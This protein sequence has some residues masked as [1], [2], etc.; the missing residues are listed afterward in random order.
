MTAS[1]TLVSGI[2][3]AGVL[4]L[5]NYRGIRELVEGAI[6]ERIVGGEYLPGTPLLQ[7]ELAD[8]FGVSR[9]PIRQALLTL[10][11]EGL[12]VSRPRRPSVVAP[13]TLKLV[14]DVYEIRAVLD[15]LAAMRAAT[16]H[17]VV[18]PELAMRLGEIVEVARE[19]TVP[20]QLLELDHQFHREIYV[21]S[22]N[23]VGLDFFDSRWVVIGRVM[24]V[25]AASAYLTTAW[26]E[27]REMVTLIEHGDGLAVRELAT[28][29][30]VRARQ[31]VVEHAH[32]L[33]SHLGDQ[34]FTSQGGDEAEEVPRNR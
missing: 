11:G 22:G 3:A 9:E 16:R 5:S 24:S 25:I 32:T 29:H 30:A 21:A 2:P 18:R 27:H 14:E 4:D 33:A 15:G 28:V 19:E 1:S 23:A 34:A 6:R 13:V 20:A 17:D 31:W 12:V 7:R 26:Q 8:S 10:E